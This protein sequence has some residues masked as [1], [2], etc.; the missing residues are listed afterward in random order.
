MKQLVLTGKGGPWELHEVPIP[1]PGPGEML[2]KVLAT[3][4]CNQTDLNTI[5]ALHPP[6]DHQITMML[7]HHFRQ[8]DK[9]LDG[10]PLAK[11]YNSIPYNREPFPT[12]MGHEGMGEVVEIGPHVVPE[13]EMLPGMGADP[14]FQVG[15][16][17]GLGGTIGGL[18]QYIVTPFREA[19]KIPDSVT[20]EEAS[21]TEPTTILWGMCRTVVRHNDTVCILGQGALG[22][23]GTQW[24][25]I[26]G[27]KTI[28]TTDPLKMKRDKS[29]AFG[30]DY[31]IDPTMQ[32][33]T[34]E[35]DK[36]TSGRGCNVVID[37]AGVS[38]TISNIPYIAGWGARIG[39]IGASC[40]PVLLDW[41][42]IHFKGMT[43][44]SAQGAMTAMGGS[45]RHMFEGSMAAVET[46]KANGRLHLSDMITH[47]LKLTVEDINALFKEIDEKGTV[48][49]A[50]I[51]PHI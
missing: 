13:F 9:R 43:V 44:Y 38:D 4:V 16:R 25:R 45:I 41:S 24:A 23:L 32:N 37:C 14:V 50:V 36:I 15:D 30:A 6:H 42:Y 3:S 49:K 2:I 20:N 1:K 48:I 21:L 33:V 39:C 29:K 27:A 31:V 47:R 22:L 34:A 11:Y 35:I 8:W 10:D 28:I 19:V 5:K 26:F 51:N 46:E 7:P 12:T 40:I 18:G 17:V